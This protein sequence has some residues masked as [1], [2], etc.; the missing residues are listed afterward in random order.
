MSE[1]V[2]IKLFGGVPSGCFETIPLIPFG[3]W[4]LSIG[5]FLLIV[6]FYAE[7]N[8]K[9]ELFSAYRYGTVLSWWKRRYGTGLAIGIRTAIFLL[10][11]VLLWDLYL[12][13]IMML[14][15]G[16]IVK[17]SILWLFH[18]VSMAA[19]FSVCDLLSIRHFVPGA[20]LLLEGV[21]F[22][23]GYRVRTVSHVMYGMWGMYSRSSL[24]EKDG[25]PAG[26]VIAAEI[27][28]LAAAFFV[29]WAYL[30]KGKII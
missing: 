4:I 3:Q 14:S 29:G 2:F 5:A 20:L 26:M 6:G 30:K 11:A 19:L 27:I 12:G 22:M 24:F 7:R 10:V 17:V 9:T 1:S 18:S 8:R 23:I 16:I 25:F 13:N 15:V 28:L 21:T